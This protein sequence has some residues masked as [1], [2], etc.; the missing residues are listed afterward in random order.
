MNLPETLTKPLSTATV[1][2]L[3]PVQKTQTIRLIDV[4]ALGPVMIL[5][6]VSAKPSK[7]VRF[8]LLLGGTATVFYNLNNYLKQRAL[9]RAAQAKSVPV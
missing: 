3:L 4:F 9:E 1:S 5:A 2:L 7:L 6:A 8:S